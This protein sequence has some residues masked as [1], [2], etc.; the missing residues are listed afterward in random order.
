M[1]P[2]FLGKEIDSEAKGSVQVHSYRVTRCSF[3]AGSS[4]SR[5]THPSQLASQDCP[6]PVLVPGR[7]TQSSLSL[8]TL[9]LHSRLPPPMSCSL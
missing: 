4:D 1:K 7:G 8:N 3:E 5:R 2:H 6:E 9:T